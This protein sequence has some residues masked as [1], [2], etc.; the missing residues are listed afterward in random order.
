MEKVLGIIAEYNP[1]H[2]GHLHHLNE[3]K[4]IANCKYSVC[5]MGGNFTQRGSCSLVDKWSK[6]KMAILNG[7]DLV[8]ELPVLYSVSRDARAA[9]DDDG[10]CRR[11]SQPEEPGPRLSG[12]G[13]AGAEMAYSRVFHAHRLLSAHDV[14]HHRCR[15]DAALFLH[16]RSRQAGGSGR[17]S[18]GR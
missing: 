2:N 16:D 1:F 10:V 6:A 4:K 15:L 12:A 17:R 11:Q 9:G 3:S 7:V 8:I 14:L 13:E 18:G 5:V